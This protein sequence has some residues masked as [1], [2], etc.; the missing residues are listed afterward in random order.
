MIKLTLVDGNTKDFEK[1]FNLEVEKP[2]K[3]FEKELL[4]IR[5]GRAHPALVEGIKVSCYGAMSNLK[6]MASISI[7]EARLIVIQPWDKSLINEIEKAIQ[8]SDLGANPVN[9]GNLIRIQLP[10]MSTTRREE[11]SKVLGK[12]LEEARIA[13]RNVRKEFHNSI[14]TAKKDGDISEDHS[15]R[16]DDILQK[17]TDT[18]IKQVETMA[19]KKEAEVKGI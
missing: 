16:L 6:E 11:L 4:A 19:A 5:T 9:D 15:N 2:I 3:H 13:V 14:R 18:A 1:S 17:L 8:A 10:G 12:K 7:P